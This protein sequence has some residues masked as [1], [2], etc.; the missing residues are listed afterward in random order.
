MYARPHHTRRREAEGAAAAAAGA[1]PPPTCTYSSSGTRTFSIRSR[2]HAPTRSFI[3]VLVP[4]LNDTVFLFQIS[5]RSRQQFPSTPRRRSS[6]RNPHC[7]HELHCLRLPLRPFGY[8]PEAARGDPY[9][10][11]QRWQQDSHGTCPPI[12][13][14]ALF[15]QAQLIRTSMEIT[16]FADDEPRD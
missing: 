15:R 6:P 7:N 1:P 14:L 13:V 5:L 10:R 11:A 12:S 16:S 2:K 8:H 9:A 3:H 4:E